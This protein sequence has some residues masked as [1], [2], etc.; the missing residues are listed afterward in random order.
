MATDATKTVRS[1][2]PGPELPAKHTFSVVELA[3]ILGLNHK[4]I[5]EQITGGAI[6]AIRL[7][8]TIRISRSEVLK[9]L[10]E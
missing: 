9:L 8:R 10:G 5:R 3:S 2:P 6:R 4:T 1:I 7:G